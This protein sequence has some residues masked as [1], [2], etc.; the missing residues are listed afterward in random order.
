MDHIACFGG[1]TYAGLVRHGVQRL[2]PC[3]LFGWLRS[4]LD[5][6]VMTC[7]PSLVFAGDSSA[8]LTTVLV[9]SSRGVS[10]SIPELREQRTGSSQREPCSFML[11]SVL[12]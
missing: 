7:L 4:Q 1:L 11:L 3:V 9:D 2:R 8:S 12:S 5:L 10:L 6:V